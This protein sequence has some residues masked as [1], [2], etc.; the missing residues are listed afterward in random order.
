MDFLELKEP[1]LFVI[2]V[3]LFKKEENEVQKG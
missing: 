3:C 1:L 2:I